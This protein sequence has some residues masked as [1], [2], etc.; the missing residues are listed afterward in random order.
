M[1]SMTDRSRAT[2][3][4]VEAGQKSLEKAEH[5]AAHRAPNRV[6]VETVDATSL[7]LAIKRA[8]PQGQP[9]RITESILKSWSTK[10]RFSSRLQNT[11]LGRANGR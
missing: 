8:H 11:Y 6:G 9:V 7:F 4:Q 3:K 5:Y 1:A 10:V 2:L